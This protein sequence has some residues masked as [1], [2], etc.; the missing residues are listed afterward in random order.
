MD[1][2]RPTHT[3]EG[4][5]PVGSKGAG[6]GSSSSSSPDMPTT[7][8][9]LA[10][11]AAS[12]SAA[13]SQRQRA[14]QG[15][16][17]DVAAHQSPGI[18]ASRPAR[19]NATSQ[20][21]EIVGRPGEHADQ[22]GRSS[23]GLG[24]TTAVP[25]RLQASSI[26]SPSSSS[27]TLTSAQQTSAS[28]NDNP[29]EGSSSSQLLTT[30]KGDYLWTAADQDLLRGIMQ[31]GGLTWRQVHQQF[32]ASSRQ[33]RSKWALRK[34]W[35]RHGQS[36]PASTQTAAGATQPGSSRRPRPNAWREDE[37]EVLRQGLAQDKTIKEVI[38]DYALKFPA[39]KR[40]AMAVETR[41]REMLKV[42]ARERDG[43]EDEQG[44]EEEEEDSDVDSE[45]D[46]AS[47]DEVHDAVATGALP[48]SESTQRWVPWSKHDDLLLVNTIIRNR[49]NRID[50]KTVLEEFHRDSDATRS[51]PA[52]DSRW[53]GLVKERPDLLQRGQTSSGAQ[54]GPSRP[55]ASTPTTVQPSLKRKRTMSDYHKPRWT[56]PEMRVLRAS[57]AK[58][59]DEPRHLSFPAVHQEFYEALP[60]STRT[61]GAL[62]AKW[63]RLVEG[64]GQPEEDDGGSTDGSDREEGEE[65]EEENC[66]GSDEGIE[67]GDATMDDTSAASP[68]T[69]R[70]R[71]GRPL[72]PL[73]EQ[74]SQ[75]NA[76][77][78]NAHRTQ[79]SRD[80]VVAAVNRQLAQQ[81]P[82]QPPA[83]PAASQQLQG[84]ASFTVLPAAAAGPSATQPY[85]T[86]SWAPDGVRIQGCMSGLDIVIFSPGSG[87]IYPHASAAPEP[88]FDQPPLFHLR[89][90]ADAEVVPVTLP[91]GASIRTKMVARVGEGAGGG[92]G[93]GGG[94][95]AMQTSFVAADYQ[96]VLLS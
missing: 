56:S 41:Y 81:R 13:T 1:D 9:A 22:A 17:S 80:A 36:T 32:N 24:S 35:K 14:S 20:P 76:T 10:Q 70:T 51:R 6:K 15:A 39:S 60:H 5:P 49:T 64:A 85:P 75:S 50:W 16:G 42:A 69:M 57:L 89:C 71:S 68:L 67:N 31:R 33:P 62:R 44:E 28:G 61:Q 47:E 93:G 27:W 63:L 72:Q 45:E 55:S 82:A 30:P 74:V 23:H 3:K 88:T 83:T 12:S 59:P 4:N 87:T 78:T 53:Y 95:M 52:I 79:T 25:Q 40:T 29:A 46:E 92:G 8:Q 73:G 94:E 65:E 91:L 77:Q 48:A 54:A 84:A 66:S 11:H 90:R 34:Q 21:P 19:S 37:D 38:C 18:S 7:Q 2:G 58:H 26:D 86:V 43:D 96:V